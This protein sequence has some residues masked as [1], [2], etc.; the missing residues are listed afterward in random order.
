[1]I[2]AVLARHAG[3]PLGSA[4][5]FVNVAGGVRIDEPGADLAVALAIASAARGVPVREGVAAFGEIGLTG[6]LRPATQADR[7][8]EECRKLGLDSVLA[9]AGTKGAGLEAETLREGAARARR[10]GREGGLSRDFLAKIPEKVALLQ[11]FCYTV[12]F[13]GSPQPPALFD[14]GTDGERD[15]LV[16]GRRQ[17]GVSAP[18]CGHGREAREARGSGQKREYLTIKI[19]HNDMTVNVPAETR[20]GSGCAR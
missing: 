4:D 10:C 3:V 13:A 18:R 8:L 20:S 16:Q 6:R 12:T 19:L 2:V 17:G 15:Q 9:P 7:R 1:M 14:D 5:V 11:G